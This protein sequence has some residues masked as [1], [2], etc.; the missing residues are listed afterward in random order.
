M[1]HI[2]YVEGQLGIREWTPPSPL[3][4]TP[5]YTPPTLVDPLPQPIIIRHQQLAA[6]PI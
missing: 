2:L 5:A 4:T 6:C 1:C 3:N